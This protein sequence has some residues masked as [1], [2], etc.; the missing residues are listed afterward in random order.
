MA[1]NKQGSEESPPKQKSRAKYPCP[2]EL[3]EMIRQV[4]LIP[5]DF[6]MKSFNTE[7]DEQRKLRREQTGSDFVVLSAMTVLRI[8][9]K[10]TPEEFQQHIEYEALRHVALLGVRESE[11]MFDFHCEN[12]KAGAY[13]EYFWMRTSM[14]DFFKILENKR[15]V[16]RRAEIE[17]QLEKGS[18]AFEQYLS[19]NWGLTPMFILTVIKRDAGGRLYCTGLPALVGTFD[20]SRLRKCEICRCI[21]WAKRD[22]AKTCSPRCLSVLHTRNSRALTDEEKAA[23]KAQRKENKAYKQKLE[24]NRSKNNVAF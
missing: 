23:K 5:P 16:T 19:L 24:E 14:M 17:N 3:A 9:L 20:D 21:Y 18:I 11:E 15:D 10:D 4:N 6:R 12:A 7:F 8:C 22:N 1:K 2:D 13:E